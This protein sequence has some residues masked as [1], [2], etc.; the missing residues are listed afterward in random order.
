MT[1]PEDDATVGDVQPGLAHPT[2]YPNPE[3]AAILPTAGQEPHDSLAEAVQGADRARLRAEAAVAERQRLEIVRRFPI[4]EWATLPLER[5]ALGL[6]SSPDG[7]CRWME[8]NTVELLSI[9]GGSALKHLIFR[10]QSGD[11]YFEKKYASLEDAWRGVRSGFVDAFR[12]AG[13]GRFDE[14]GQ[15]DGINA[16]IS[17]STKAV[18][19]YFPNELMPIAAGAHQ[20]H[21]WRLL[22]GDGPIQRGVPAARQ[23]LELVRSLPHFAGW[24]TWEVMRFLYDWA[25]P[26]STQQIVKIAPGTDANLW[27]DCL[28]NGYIRVGWE[29]TGDLRE[30]ESKDEFAAKFAA[31]YTDLYKGNGAKLTEKATEVWT[32]I[33]LHAGDIV[34]ANRGT[35]RVMGIGRVTDKGY[36]FRPDLDSYSHTV[37]ISWDDPVIR[38]IDPI[39]RWAFKTV[40]PVS[41][42]EYLQILKGKSA[43]G[44]SAPPP[45]KPV[46]GSV[47]DKRLR[48]IASELDRKGQLILY[49]PPGTGKTYHAR[50]FATWW[51]SE[52]LK[53]GSGLAPLQ[54]A[55]AFRS[56]EESLSRAAADRRIWWV[57]ANP[58]EWAWEQLF[59]DGTVDYRY[60]RMQRNYA[61]LQEGDLVIGYQA[62]PTKRIMAVA[63]ITK[64]LHQ[65]A[66]GLEI[67][68]GPVHQVANGPTW[69]EMLADPRLVNSEPIHNRSQGTLFA[70]TADEGQYLLAWLQE[71]DPSLPELLPRQTISWSDR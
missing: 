69:A 64:T 9:K 66:N 42:A 63:R 54:D 51:L 28:Q 12:L 15:L 27:D 32:L 68:L 52:Q 6:P 35:S 58:A 39:K 5:Y 23:L 40:A 65:T 61:H 20:E 11:W 3:R 13:E 4:D 10:R 2:K 37:S 43:P 31:E 21:F 30:F 47:V 19:C 45:K 56:A 14:I 67:S 62:N 41:Q 24:T 33:N 25:D 50:R 55:T 7:F 16:A 49:G 36:E 22:G 38:D 1:Q 44:L 53:P 46:F 18:Y 60:G 71:R 59:K 29:G 34:I 48:E 57:T 70:L 8:F 17:L 26:R